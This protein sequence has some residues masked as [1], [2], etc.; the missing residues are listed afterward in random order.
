[1]ARTTARPARTGW[2]WTYSSRRCM[3]IEGRIEGPRI[4]SA[5]PTKLAPMHRRA[6]RLSL[7]AFVAACVLGLLPAALLSGAERARTEADLKAIASQIEK[8][9]QEVRRNAVERD[10]LARDLAEAEG[11]VAKTRTELER[12]RQQR[13]EREQARA[14]LAAE[15]KQSEARLA[16]ERDALAAQIRA[17]YQTGPREPLRLLLDQQDPGRIGRTFAY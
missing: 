2:C 4:I 10:R 16:R 11:S 6:A 14:R 9:R 1:M 12:L 8:V 15:K 13:G 17:A 3:R 7:P 5:P